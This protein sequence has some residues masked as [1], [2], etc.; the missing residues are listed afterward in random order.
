MSAPVLIVGGGIGGLSAALALAREDLPV[1]LL[2]AAPEFAEIGAGLQ[3]GP[4]GSRILAG[5]GLAGALAVKARRPSGLVLRDGLSGRRLARMP[6]G[7]DAE[8][9]YG[10]PYLAMPRHA[11]HSVLLEAARA[12]PNITL[13]CGMPVATSTVVGDAVFIG[14]ANGDPPLEGRALVAA[15]GVHSGLRK[16]FF[17]A[18][19]R[20]S[21]RTALRALVS[22]PASL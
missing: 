14:G 3:I 2:E 1:H 10:A 15:D 18:R 12:S 22:I 5:W 4:N 13:S 21:G 20:P 16:A 17:G 7:D 11:L 6:L 9:R 8:A 19:A